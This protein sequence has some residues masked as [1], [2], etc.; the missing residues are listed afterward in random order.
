MKRTTHPV[1]DKAEVSIDF[2]D[3]VYMGSFSRSSVFEARAE[4]DGLF[5]KLTRP[6]EDTREVEIHLHHHLLAD[7][8]DAWADSLAEQPPMDADHKKTLVDALNKVEKALKK[9]RRRRA[10]KPNGPGRQ[11]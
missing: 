10:A 4:N 3:K 2:P 1:H 11:A 8:L 6:G 9:R 5:V 7:I